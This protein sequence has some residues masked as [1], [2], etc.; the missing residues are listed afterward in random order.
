MVIKKRKTPTF[1]IL[2]VVFCTFLTS[3][4]QFLIKKGTFFIADSFWS[5][6]NVPLVSGFAL[7]ALG[8]V[9]LVIALKYGE[10]SV[11]YP[12]IALSFIWVFLFSI[13]LLEEKIFFVNWAG[14]VLIILGVSLIGR[15]GGRE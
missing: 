2:M 6:F 9:I 10:L 14:L 3:T 15:G 11:L 13:F 7:Y 4:G 12:F 1:A 8:A 5:I